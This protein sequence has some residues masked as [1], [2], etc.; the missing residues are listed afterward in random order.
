M[1]RT[2]NPFDNQ[3][4]K[5]EENE[6]L[7]SLTEEDNPEEQEPEQEV[8][9]ELQENSEEEKAESDIPDKYK[10][11][12]LE[13]IVRMHQEAEKLQGRQSKEV[14][15]LRKSVDELLKMKLNEANSTKE[16]EPEYSKA[17]AR[18]FS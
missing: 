14:G 2:I 5:L 11:K 18:T 3:E 7:V 12:S 16:E 17:D 10:G 6:E 13:D 9:Q 15:E 4:I 1:A 8:E